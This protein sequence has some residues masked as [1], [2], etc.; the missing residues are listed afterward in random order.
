M[1]RAEFLI[2]NQKVLETLKDF[3]NTTVG[4][5]N[6]L[7]LGSVGLISHTQKVNYYRKIKDIDTIADSNNQLQIEAK[8][9]KRGY[10]K[11]TFIDDKMPF[12]KIL[13][14]FLSSR[15][16]RFSIQGSSDLEILFTPFISANN[17]LQQNYFHFYADL[18]R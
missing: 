15:Y 10:T 5:Q 9:I 3:A 13:K 16:T 8:L 2:E 18:Y 17:M 14:R 4:L 1:T 12:A 6:I 11:S 7:I